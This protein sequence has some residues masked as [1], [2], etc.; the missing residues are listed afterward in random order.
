VLAGF[1]IDTQIEGGI[2]LLKNRT[3]SGGREYSH[4]EIPSVIGGGV[5]TDA[6][7]ID[8]LDRMQKCVVEHVYP[9]HS[10]SNGASTPYK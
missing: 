3:L 4:S 1:K 7:K 9:P 6:A 5:Q 10:Q 2:S 8:I